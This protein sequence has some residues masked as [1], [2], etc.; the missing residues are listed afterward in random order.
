LQLFSNERRN[1]R[2]YKTI[3]PANF[4]GSCREKNVKPSGTAIKS[5]AR[6]LDFKTLTRKIRKR[7]MASFKESVNEFGTRWKG[8]MTEMEEIYRSIE[9]AR[10]LSEHEK[11]KLTADFTKGNEAL[12]SEWITRTESLF[13]SHRHKKGKSKAHIK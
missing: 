9:N 5:S 10:D 12:I 11:E 8:M 3:C 6:K 4:S 13:E 1:S 2:D 7:R